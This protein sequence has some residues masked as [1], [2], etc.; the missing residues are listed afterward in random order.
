MQVTISDTSTQKNAQNNGYTGYHLNVSYNM[1]GISTSWTLVKRYSQFFQ[2]NT[3]LVRAF[4]GIASQLPRFPPKILLN[5]TPKVISDRQTNLQLWLTAVLQT[6]HLVASP[7]IQGFL[8]V[9]QHAVPVTTVTTT[10]TTTSGVPSV[11]PSLNMNLGG[12]N[13]NLSGG[14]TTP[15]VQATTTVVSTT[16]PSTPYSATATTPYYTDPSMSAYPA[17]TI[18]TQYNTGYPTT[19]NYSMTV[20]ANP[21]DPYAVNAS[22][23]PMIS[24]GVA[25]LNA[26]LSFNMTT[27]HSSSSSSS[28]SMP[29]VQTTTSTW[30]SSSQQQQPASIMSAWSSSPAIDAQAFNELLQSFRDQAFSDD[31]LSFINNFFKNHYFT[32]DQAVQLIE[33][34]S[35]SDEVVAAA[36]ALHPRLVDQDKFFKVL[37]KVTFDSD[38]SKI[39]SSLGLL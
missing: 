35:F 37:D 29:Y 9:A 18:Q 24:V 38:K 12:L 25:P 2:L 30:D 21:H 26:N 7:H 6:P 11:T 36:I 10:T 32:S 39:K 13:F 1:N 23:N 34:C 4:P 28:S 20:S 22:I 31:K 5:M 15:A 19:D 8:E 3:V 27:S 33:A 16:G 17:A 14:V